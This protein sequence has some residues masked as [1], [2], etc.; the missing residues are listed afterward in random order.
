MQIPGRTCRWSQRTVLCLAWTDGNPLISASFGHSIR[1]S[2]WKQLAVLN[3][4]TWFVESVAVSPN[5]RILAG[6]GWD[7]TARLWNLDNNQPISSP[8]QHADTVR[9]V[10]FSEDEKLLSTGCYDENAYTWDVSAIVEEAG[11]D[12]LLLDQR[13]KSLLAAD[14][15]RRPV[16]RPIKVSNQVPQGFF[17]GMPYRTYVRRLPLT[18]CLS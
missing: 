12:D 15:T 9:S 18:C 8:L 14:A 13:D 7:R 1:T 6:A 11:L 16:R 4:R 2:T 17:D 10:S 5:G 3:R